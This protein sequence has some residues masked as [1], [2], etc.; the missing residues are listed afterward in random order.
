MKPLK[1]GREEIQPLKNLCQSLPSHTQ[2]PP[3]ALGMA[4]FTMEKANTVSGL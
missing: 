2:E 4:S 1:T 3:D